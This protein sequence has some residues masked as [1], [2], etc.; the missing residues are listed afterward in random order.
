MYHLGEER[1]DRAARHDDRAF[2]AERAAGADRDG[3]RDWFQHRH[4]GA[5]PAL[6]DQDGLDGFGYAMTPDL[7]GPE[8]RHQAD[9]EATGNRDQHGP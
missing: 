1:A 6:A 7:F 3:G 2:G 4:L 8:P 5:D 9:D